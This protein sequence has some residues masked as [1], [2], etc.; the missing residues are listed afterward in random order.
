MDFITGLPV[1]QGKDCIYVMVNKLSKF[2][3]LFAI[4]ARYSILQVA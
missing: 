4:S 1:V 3:H 2:A